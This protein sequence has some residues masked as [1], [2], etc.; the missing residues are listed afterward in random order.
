MVT[1]VVNN[2]YIDLFLSFFFFYNVSSKKKMESLN[3]TR[4]IGLE[5]VR[6]INENRSK[7]K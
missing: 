3:L 6:I 1:F 5:G 7:D 4:S 2:R